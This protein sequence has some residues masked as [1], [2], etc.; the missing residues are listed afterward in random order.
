MKKLKYEKFAKIY[1]TIFI[2]FIHFLDSIT[3]FYYFLFL[4]RSIKET[5]YRKNLRE[6]FGFYKASLDKSI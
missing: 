3:A 6:R 5:E 1:E 4:K 2:Y